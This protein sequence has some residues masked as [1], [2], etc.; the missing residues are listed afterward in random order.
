MKNNKQSVLSTLTLILQLGITMLVPIVALTIFGA[1]LGRRFDAM[2]I[3][4]LFFCLGALG[5]AQGAWRIIK[6]VIR[7]WS[8]DPTSRQSLRQE[9]EKQSESIKEDE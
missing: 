6:G 7:D 1:Y 2:W 9:K 8:I 3:P 4:V 5:G